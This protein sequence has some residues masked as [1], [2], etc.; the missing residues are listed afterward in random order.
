MAEK[1]AAWLWRN[2]MH[3]PFCVGELEWEVW[4]E[5]KGPSRSSGPQCKKV[6]ML[7]SCSKVD[8][9]VGGAQVVYHRLSKSLP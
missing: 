1:H 8:D 2:L 4:V 6:D 5:S 7:V 3:A 9:A